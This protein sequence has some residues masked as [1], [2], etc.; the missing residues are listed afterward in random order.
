MKMAWIVHLY[1]SKDQIKFILMACFFSFNFRWFRNSIP[2]LFDKI[3][4]Y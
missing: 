4:G 3:S 1:L 2:V